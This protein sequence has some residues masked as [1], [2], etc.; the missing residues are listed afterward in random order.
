MKINITEP[1]KSDGSG[2]EM[3]AGG[4]ERGVGGGGKK[5]KSERRGRGVRVA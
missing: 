5:G 3:P 4:R 1:E 2:E